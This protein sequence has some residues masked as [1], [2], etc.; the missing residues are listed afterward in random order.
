MNHRFVITGSKQ[1]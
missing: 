1:K